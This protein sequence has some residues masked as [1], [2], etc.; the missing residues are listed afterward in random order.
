MKARELYLEAERSLCDVGVVSCLII[1]HASKQI[2][3]SASSD[4]CASIEVLCVKDVHPLPKRSP[5]LVRKRAES[6]RVCAFS[7]WLT[8]AECPRASSLNA[9]VQLEWGAHQL[10][11]HLRA[12]E[13]RSGR[14][15]S[16]SGVKP[17]WTDTLRH[18]ISSPHSL[19]GT[20]P[21]PCVKQFK[22][23]SSSSPL[24]IFAGLL[25]SRSFLFPHKRFATAQN[26][27]RSWLLRANL[28]LSCDVIFLIRAWFGDS[29]SFVFSSILYFSFIRGNAPSR[30]IKDQR[31]VNMN[32]LP[33]GIC[34]YL[35]VTICWLTA[36][37]DASWW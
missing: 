21:T 37:V 22:P 8:L 11:P 17:A 28:R 10:G 30:S 4:H 26:P 5:Y 1:Y 32:L 18:L 12:A 34:F 3:V 2:P 9:S 31:L 15:P 35:S 24:K 33:S 13:L 25:D 16:L 7:W 27:S 14:G 36:G 20:L 6:K 23:D 29:T 19:D